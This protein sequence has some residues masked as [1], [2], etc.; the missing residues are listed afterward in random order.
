MSHDFKY[1]RV[2]S[3]VQAEAPNETWLSTVQEG[4]NM[5]RK[6]GWHPPNGALH[7]AALGSD[8]FRARARTGFHL[9]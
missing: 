7:L 1:G 8:V 6:T 3:T 2:D 5:L 9:G 4:S